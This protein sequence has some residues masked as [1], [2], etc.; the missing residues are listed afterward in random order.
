MAVRTEIITVDGRQLVRTYS[1]RVGYG[2]ARDGVV[3]GEA[4]DPV[5]SGREYVEAWDGDGD[6]ELSDSE[7]LRVITGGAEDETI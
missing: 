1:D 7:A 3:Y 2:V 4:I 6:E 5:G